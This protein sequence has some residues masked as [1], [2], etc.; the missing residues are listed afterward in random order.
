MITILKEKPIVPLN[1]VE[2]CFKLKVT[3]GYGEHCD[4]FYTD[5]YVVISDKEGE[6]YIT[7]NEA[8]ELVK[9]FDSLWK[10]KDKDGFEVD[11]IVINE[12]V[13]LFWWK[14]QGGMTDDEFYWF[15]CV[16]KRFE[17]ALFN[18]K[19]EHEW[20]GVVNVQ[21]VYIDSNNQAHP[22]KVS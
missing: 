3:L 16:Y 17:T 1:R 10:R 9:F 7:Q 11:H 4:D 18:P 19:T 6:N 5:S 13:N 22:C 2:P 15:A 14:D 12:G 8:E 21:I 20:C